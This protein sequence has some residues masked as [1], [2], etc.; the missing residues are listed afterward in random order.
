[1]SVLM[2]KKIA[3]SDG[4]VCKESS[5]TYDYDSALKILSSNKQ[6][7][8]SRVE[9]YDEKVT[10]YKKLRVCP[11]CG[12]ETPRYHPFVLNSSDIKEYLD[13]KNNISFYIKPDEHNWVCSK[14][15]QAMKFLVL[16]MNL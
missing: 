1:M 6:M 14:C 2:K 11:Y 16:I 7:E 5:K 4:Y 3:L 9:V 12:C 13:Y 8:I 15:I 10:I